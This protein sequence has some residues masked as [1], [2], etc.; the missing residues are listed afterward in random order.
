MGYFISAIL[1]RRVALKPTQGPQPHHVQAIQGDIKLTGK[2]LTFTSRL[3]A[4]TSRTTNG[5]TRLHEA[6]IYALS[7]QGGTSEL[8]C[9]LV[10][11]LSPKCT[12]SRQVKLLK[13]RTTL[14]YFNPLYGQIATAIQSNQPASAQLHDLCVEI[15]EIVKQVFTKYNVW[16]QLNLIGDSKQQFCTVI[17]EAATRL[18]ITSWKEPTQPGPTAVTSKISDTALTAL[19]TYYPDGIPSL[20]SHEVAPNTFKSTF[21]ALSHEQRFDTVSQWITSSPLATMTLLGQDGQTALGK[22]LG[23]LLITALAESDADFQFTDGFTV[24]TPKNGLALKIACLA[25][26]LMSVDAGR[27][28]DA[29]ATELSSEHKKTIDG[30][31][32]EA[33]IYKVTKRILFF[34]NY[35]RDYYPRSPLGITLLDNVTTCIQN[36]ASRIEKVLKRATYATESPFTTLLNDDWLGLVR[37]RISYAS[38]SERPEVIQKFMDQ[39]TEENFRNVLLF[40]SEIPVPHRSEAVIELQ[41]ALFNKAPNI[42]MSLAIKE[43]RSAL[44][45]TPDAAPWLAQMTKPTVGEF[46]EHVSKRSDFSSTRL[47]EPALTAIKT[48]YEMGRKYTVLPDQSLALEHQTAQFMTRTEAI[49]VVKTNLQIVE[50]ALKSGKIKLPKPIT[51]E[52]AGLL[53]V[54]YVGEPIVAQMESLCHGAMSRRINELPS[55]PI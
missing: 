12:D 5:T 36:G 50:G 14:L 31:E 22:Q 39:I 34:Y 28:F 9:A 6:L 2:A 27:V 10:D 38:R 4:Y 19:C 25:D 11:I 7:D 48:I 23:L 53:A 15:A 32:S 17:D 52:I 51:A 49:L 42:V 37:N 46:L 20:R 18:L 44:A 30:T 35:V 16:S 54:I 1:N 29:L 45:L 47:P 41:D 3:S 43:R 33:E 8:E 55:P 40:F 26:A 21:H 24:D 13:V